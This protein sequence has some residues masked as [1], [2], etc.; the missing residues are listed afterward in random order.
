MT[1]YKI[2]KDGVVIDANFKFFRYQRKHLNIIK[3]DGKCAELVQSS[4]QKTF[5]RA[6]WLRPLPEKARHHEIAEV[7]IIDEAEYN[8]LKEQLQLGNI[9]VPQSIEDEP[10]VDIEPVVE[11][12]KRELILS[13]R[14]LYERIQRL[15]EKVKKLENK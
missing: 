7:V 3:C 14:E 15:E 13:I 11:K 12:P 8:E 5:Y 2:I 9:I 1:Y 4:D 10:V 6:E